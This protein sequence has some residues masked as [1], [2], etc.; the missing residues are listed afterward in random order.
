MQLSQIGPVAVPI[1]GTTPIPLLLPP[2]EKASSINTKAGSTIVSTDA[3]AQEMANTLAPSIL[4]MAHKKEQS[5]S[6]GST[7]KG[8]AKATRHQ[9]EETHGSLSSKK[10]NKPNPNKR[11]ERKIEGVR[12]IKKLC[13]DRNI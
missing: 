13:Y 8:G 6:S 11:K 3:V 9:K 4:Q 2:S 5:Q 12:K 7:T 1:P 10:G